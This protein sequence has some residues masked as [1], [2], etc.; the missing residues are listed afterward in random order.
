MERDEAK[1]DGRGT[2]HDLI[3]VDHLIVER[4]MIDGLMGRW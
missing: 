4:A 1:I 2:S 3:T